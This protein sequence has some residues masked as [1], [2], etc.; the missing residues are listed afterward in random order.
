[1]PAGHPEVDHSSGVG[2]EGGQVCGGDHVDADGGRIGRG[3]L[4]KMLVFE[5]SLPLEC[6][7]PLGS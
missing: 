4:H 5:C 3:E 6:S 2:W 7:P 1:M